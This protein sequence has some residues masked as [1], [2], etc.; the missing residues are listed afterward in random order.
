MPGMNP[1]AARQRALLVWDATRGLDTRISCRLDGDR[2]VDALAAAI[3]TGTPA[4]ITLAKTNTMV[5]ALDVV[6]DPEKAWPG[7]VWVESHAPGPGEWDCGRRLDGADGVIERLNQFLNLLFSDTIYAPAE[8]LAGRIGQVNAVLDY[9]HAFNPGHVP[10]P[11]FHRQG[12]GRIVL[13]AGPAA[14]PYTKVLGMPDFSTRL[15][16]VYGVD[17]FMGAFVVALLR[18]IL[19]ATPVPCNFF[20]SGAIWF[21][22]SAYPFPITAAHVVSGDG[23]DLGE[24]F[25]GF[26]ALALR[27][28]IVE[29]SD[30][31]INFAYTNRQERGA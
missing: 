20:W 13:T 1:L 28:G 7:C 9:A 25:D 6:F 15:Q 19:D 29:H 26:R 30:S 8:T 21:Q 23:F 27:M 31:D 12:N 3:H 24:A 17:S 14:I 10:V 2:V 4:R 16:A 5:F 18:F 11:R 22:E